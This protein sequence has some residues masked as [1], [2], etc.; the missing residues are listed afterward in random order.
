MNRQLGALALALA[1]AGCSSSA[2]TP[3]SPA[4][5]RQS[6]APQGYTLQGVLKPTVKV[7]PRCNVS[8]SVRTKGWASM[9]RMGLLTRP[10][11]VQ[12]V[13]ITL[14]ALQTG[15]MGPGGDYP[16]RGSLSIQDDKGHHITGRVTTL[17]PYTLDDGRQAV[18][19]T[20][21]QYNHSPFA[22][23]AIDGD[24]THGIVYPGTDQVSFQCRLGPTK[25][26]VYYIQAYDY[27][28]NAVIASDNGGVKIDPD[29]FC[30]PTKPKS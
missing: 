28:F 11:D 30:A 12:Q 25:P 6:V 5:D 21:V 17:R 8:V 24:T 7:T 26:G 29:E 23:T 14:D 13:K 2:V 3:T 10:G 15:G 27:H 20:G 22:L 4:G 16:A 19:L 18:D 1:I 9:Q